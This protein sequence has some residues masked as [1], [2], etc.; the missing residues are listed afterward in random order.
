[1]YKYEHKYKERQIEKYR[2]TLQI[3]LKWRTKGMNLA[4]SK[5]FVTDYAM[6]I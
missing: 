6:L 3:L 5:L 4:L 2:S 1:M